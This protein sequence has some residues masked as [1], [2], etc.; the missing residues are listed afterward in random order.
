MRA[1]ITLGPRAPTAHRLEAD[2][3]SGRMWCPAC[4]A[5]APPLPDRIPESF[6]DLEQ[7]V[8][9][10]EPLLHE[11]AREGARRDWQEGVNAG[12]GCA[13]AVGRWGPALRR[14]GCDG[15]REQAG[16]PLC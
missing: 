3:I 1:Q 16:T 10:F 12:K 9:T 4:A 11:E 5:A 13:V 8:S 6:D 7:Y 2:V 15:G 14:R